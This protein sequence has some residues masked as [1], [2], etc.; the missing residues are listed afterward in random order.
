[1]TAFERWKF[2]AKTYQ[3]RQSVHTLKKNKFLVFFMLDYFSTRRSYHFH[4]ISN[5]FGNQFQLKAVHRKTTISVEYFNGN[6][7]QTHLKLRFSRHTFIIL[8]SHSLLVHKIHMELELLYCIMTL[9]K[10]SN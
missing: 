10:K 7:L 8:S 4:K 9:E 3:K 6:C 1:M 5:C 2:F